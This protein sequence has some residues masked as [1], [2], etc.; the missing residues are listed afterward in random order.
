MRRIVKGCLLIGLLVTGIHL[1]A[2]FF[3][4]LS[5]KPPMQ[6]HISE[7]VSY[8]TCQSASAERSDLVYVLEIT[9]AN[10]RCACLWHVDAATYALYEIGDQ[11]GKPS[12]MENSSIL[13]SLP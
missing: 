9:D 2:P 5:S 12:A 4:Q 13:E 6:G 3:T 8:C 7:K 10:G 1:S 11:A